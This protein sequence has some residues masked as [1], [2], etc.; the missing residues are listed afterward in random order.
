MSCVLVKSHLTRLSRKQ[1]ETNQSHLHLQSK[2]EPERQK[3]DLERYQIGT[4]T[5][6]VKNGNGMGTVWEQPGTEMFMNGTGWNVNIQERNA[7]ERDRSGTEREETE[8][9]AT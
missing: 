5:R 8:R 3:M 6:T 7:K 1:L 9:S 4:V 2:M